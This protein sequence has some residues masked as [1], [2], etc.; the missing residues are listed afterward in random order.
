MLSL[1][2]LV[3][4][5]ARYRGD[6]PAVTVEGETLT[7][8][9]FAER[10]N[11]VANLLLACGI[12]PGD[13]VAT[14]LGNGRELLEIYW[15]VPTIGAVLVPLSP[16]LNA[17]GLSSLLRDSGARAVFTQCSMLREFEAL[18]A[19]I[20]AQLG[21]RRFL[22]DGEAAGF[23]A[24][25]A[26]VDSAPADSPAVRV[27]QEALFNIMYTSGTTGAPKGIQHTHA[28]RAIYALT[29][30][31]AWRMTPE[32]VVMHA[33]AIVFNGA[34]VTLMPAF[35]LGARYVLLK[36]FDPEVAI[37]AIAREKVTH[38]ML[39]PA[40]IIAILASPA[41]DVAKLA[42]LEM[43]LSLGAPLLQEHKDRLNALLPG[44]FHELYGLTEGFVT[45]LDK[46]DAV[47]KSG[48][49]GVPPVFCELRIVD[50]AGREV[51][52]GE[53]GEIVGRAP[54]LMSG[55]AGRDDL[56]AQAVREGW[57]Q[58]GDLGR[59]DEEGFLYLVDRK[60]DMIDSGG[61]KV[62]P[63]DI[64]EIAAR[65]PAVLDVA[66]FGV[67]DAKWGE[68][69]VAAVTLVH[70]GAATALELRNWINERVS[71]R[72][73]RV[74]EVVIHAEFPRN[75]AGKTLK[76]DLRAPYWKALGRAI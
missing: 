47:R 70:P 16:L 45:I 26:A 19:G 71:A 49:V 53:V 33:G 40:Q 14:V 13:K 41:F 17:P 27:P 23:T 51:P 10:V 2:G 60:K 65:H 66:V 29:M 37:E 56:T 11:R 25:A 43:I 5:H 18:D 42:S 76:R 34:F 15:A 74:L 22:V 59:V 67:P 73:Q 75:A 48:S 28:T 12:A 7:W 57:L 9:E 46:R 35:Y 30:A 8:R 69:P 4:H 1:A 55:Y 68:T 36:A 61:V 52:T 63:K 62:Y 20:A 50:D 3:D 31:P 54:L 24:Y 64:E 72:Y 44:R 32:S 58:T 21:S 39:V 6:L 38:T